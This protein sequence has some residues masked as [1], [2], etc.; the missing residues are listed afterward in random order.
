VI[1]CSSF[2]KTIAPGYRIGWIATG[3]HMQRVLEQKLASTLSNPALPQAAL[4][5]FLSSGGY[6]SH[7]R[8]I[9]RTFAENIDQMMRAIE[10]AFPAG[11][12]VSRPAGG[13][14]LWVELAKPINTRALFKEAL[15]RG[16][17][18][19]PGDVFSASGRYAHCLRLSCGHA[20]DRRLQ[21]GL[22]TIGAIATAAMADPLLDTGIY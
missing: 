6:D 15:R 5:D 21:G 2:S 14:V 17:C 22:E 11:T 12:K 19:V 18:F 9:R 10:Q 13:F 1:Y 3:R 4:A 7:L 8:R 16:V 20:W